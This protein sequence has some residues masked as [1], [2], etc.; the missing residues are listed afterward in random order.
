MFG[1]AANFLCGATV[2]LGAAC[3]AAELIDNRTNYSCYKITTA[4]NAL[5]NEISPDQKRSA[6]AFR[7]QSELLDKLR[8]MRVRISTSILPQIRADWNG[9]VEAA[10]FAA[11]GAI[12]RASA[13]FHRLQ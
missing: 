8:D 11:D 9:R 12:K 5:R 6:V 10:A 2:S 3:L 13:E 4:A 1:F 7:Q